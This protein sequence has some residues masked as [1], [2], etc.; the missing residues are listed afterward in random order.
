MYFF[1]FSTYGEIL[2]FLH[3]KME[4]I[5]KYYKIFVKYIE[6]IEKIAVFLQQAKLK[7]VI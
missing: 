5:T 3:H 4:Y 7:H 6:K 2:A 1:R